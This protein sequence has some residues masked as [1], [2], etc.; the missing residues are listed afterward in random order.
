MR[1]FMTL[2]LKGYQKYGKAKSK[3]PNLRN[4]SW[5]FNKEK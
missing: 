3:H 1:Y 5:N 4:K 2:Y